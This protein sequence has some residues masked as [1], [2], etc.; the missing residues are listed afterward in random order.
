VCSGGGGT[1]LPSGIV[2]M[3]AG[4][5]TISSSAGVISNLT[6]THDLGVIPSLF[7]F[8]PTYEFILADNVNYMHSFVLMCKQYT[9]NSDV[10]LGVK[11]YRYP[12]ASGLQGGVS[13]VSNTDISEQTACVTANANCKLKAGATYKWVAIAM[14]GI[15]C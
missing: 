4:E 5:H 11:V 12:T 9:K 14:E 3:K 13:S 2:A 8:V 6:I 10:V 15:N 7:Y 1:S